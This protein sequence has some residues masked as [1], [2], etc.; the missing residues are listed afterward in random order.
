MLIGHRGPSRG[1]PSGSAVARRTSAPLSKCRPACL[2]ASPISPDLSRPNPTDPSPPSPPPESPLP[3]PRAAAATSTAASLRSRSTRASSPTTCCPTTSRRP[4]WSPTCH[5]RGSTRRPWSGR[6]PTGPAAC[7]RAPRP[8][9][10]AP[11][12][13]MRMHARMGGRACPAAGSRQRR[14]RRSVPAPLPRRARAP[15]RFRLATLMFPT[16]G[17]RC[18]RVCASNACAQAPSRAAAGPPPPLSSSSTFSTSH[19][20]C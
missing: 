4:T 7:R 6:A 17:L 16:T 19:H 8:A 20:P 5:M 1:A 18:V 3:P 2:R 11:P 9:R 12:C 10:E 14:P 15:G 13:A